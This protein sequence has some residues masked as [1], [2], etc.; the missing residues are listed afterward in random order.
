MLSSDSIIQKGRYRIIRKFGTIGTSIV[1]DAFDNLRAANVVIAETPLA[2]TRVLTVA[3]REAQA[4]RF[5]QNFNLAKLI[6]NDR[7]VRYAEQFVEVD[8]HYVVTESIGQLTSPL[9]F[10][11][12]SADEIN[13]AVEIDAWLTLADEIRNRFPMIS[14]IEITPTSVRMDPTMRTRLLFLGESERFVSQ[15]SYSEDGAELAYLPLESIWPQLDAASQKAI[16]NTYNDLSLERLES[17][18]DLTS[19]IYSIAAM[20]FRIGSGQTPPNALERSIELLEGSADSLIKSIELA[21]FSL[22]LSN[23]FARALQI[24]RE[25]RFESFAE[26]RS[27]LGNLKPAAPA[28]NIADDHD[29]LELPPE[30]VAAGPRAFSRRSDIIEIAP[31]T[32]PSIESPKSVVPEQRPT[33][34]PAPIRVPTAIAYSPKAPPAVTRSDILDAPIIYETPVERV[35]KPAAR[36]LLEPSFEMVPV[37][38]YT[39]LFAGIIAIVVL[40]GSVVTYMMTQTSGNVVEPAPQATVMSEPR[41]EPPTISQPV[42]AAEPEKSTSIETQLPAIQQPAGDKPQQTAKPERIA[43]ADTRQPKKAA[44]TTDPKPEP[45]KKKTVT[46]D[47]LISDN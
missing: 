16:S 46:V 4:R 30:P 26:A 9:A 5:E 37:R 23:F 43:V 22:E 10:A 12:R 14:N 47:D 25:D 27:V 28:W 31:G 44:E 42:V 41:P 45:K 40:A 20:F 8:R 11:R 2:T 17:P 39:A 13:I 1:Y 33:P 38:S 19:D 3:E 36:P 6:S 15:Q 32:A 21:G 24:K 35:P 34:V 29:L 7:L 18:P